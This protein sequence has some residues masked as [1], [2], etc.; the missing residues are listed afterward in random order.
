VLASVDFPVE[1][2]HARAAA[3]SKHPTWAQAEGSPLPLGVTWIQEEQA[4]NF[5]VIRPKN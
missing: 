2:T 1:A 3:L 4:F 5:A